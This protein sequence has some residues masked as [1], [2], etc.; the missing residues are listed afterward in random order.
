MHAEYGTHDDLLPVRV[1]E[2]TGSSFDETK[3]KNKKENEREKKT[4][5]K[6]KGFVLRRTFRIV[7][8]KN[9]V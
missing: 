1:G 7:H 2:C 6:N 5:R 8:I 3:N 9:S 4:D